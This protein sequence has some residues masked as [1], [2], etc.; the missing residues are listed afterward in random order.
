MVVVVVVDDLG[1]WRLYSGDEKKVFGLSDNYDDDD[2]VVMCVMHI[3]M[4]VCMY[5]CMHVCMYV[6]TVS[7]THQTLTTKCSV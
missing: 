5:V 6:C 4:Y 7:Y 2:D 3:C 1:G